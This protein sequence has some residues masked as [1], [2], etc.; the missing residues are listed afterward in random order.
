MVMFFFNDASKV[1]VEGEGNILIKLKDETQKFISSVYYVPKMK[2]NIL[3]LGQL[4]EYGH[5]IFMKD[6]SL[7]LRDKSNRL[8]TQV[9][10]GTDR[11]FKLNLV[12]IEATC[13]KTCVEEKDW[14]WHLRF[15]HINFGGLKE[16][17]SK[18]MVHGLP[19]VDSPDKFCEG[20]VIGKHPRSS[21]PKVAEY[22]A[23][24]P[25]ELVHT[26]ICGLIQPSSIGENQY[27]I[28]FIDDFSHKTWVYFLKEKS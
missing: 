23:K 11:M 15:G 25:L 6:R 2:S 17:A 14:L 26:D 24:N 19:L 12:N 28:T 1:C 21:F 10:M 18:K 13:L 4:L 20:C 5:T 27:F 22:R 7:Y 3:S 9:E 16:I 8:I